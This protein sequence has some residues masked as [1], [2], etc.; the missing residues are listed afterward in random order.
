MLGPHVLTHLLPA[1]RSIWV[2]SGGMYAQRLVTDDLEYLKT[3]YK[4]VH[5]DEADV[6]RGRFWHDRGPRPEHYLGLHRESEADRR[7]LWNAIEGLSG[8]SA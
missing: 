3:E 6:P 8:A 7:T 2:S 5:A 4:G 1:E